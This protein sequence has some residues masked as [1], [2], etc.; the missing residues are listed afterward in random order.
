LSTTHSKILFSRLR[1]AANSPQSCGSRCIGEQIIGSLTD[2]PPSHTPAGS[3]LFGL[4]RKDAT[5]RVGATGFIMGLQLNH[6]SDEG[7]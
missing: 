2:L 1:E 4:E 6:H 7:D 3:F 5:D